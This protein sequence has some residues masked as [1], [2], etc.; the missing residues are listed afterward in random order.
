MAEMTQ[1]DP[2]ALFEEWFS[3]ACAREPVNPNAMALATADAE[4]RPTART[5]LLKS[6][7]ARGFVFYTNLESRKGRQ[8]AGNPCAALLFYW[9]ALARQIHIEGALALVDAA[10]ADAYFATRPRESQ[11]AAWAS[12]QSRPMPRGRSDF[13]EAFDAV[14]RR[15]EGATV[16][17]PPQ[18]SGFR[19][20][21]ER[22][23]FWQEGDYRMHYRREF[24]R[25]ASGEWDVAELF[26]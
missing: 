3:G 2:F 8:I 16:P 18:W 13:E 21:P 5:V 19:L 11:L 14:R 15:F 1:D 24:R 4:G 23:E 25:R 17:R 9:R 7:D 6:W 12:Q 22:I 20:A 10:E 26:P